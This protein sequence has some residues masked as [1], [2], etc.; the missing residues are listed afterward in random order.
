[1]FQGD[2]SMNRVRF[3][4][5][6]LVLLFSNLPST[7]QPVQAQVDAPLAVDEA[8]TALVSSGVTSYTLADPKIFWH[9]GVPICPPAGP[10][11]AESP[12][13][14]YPE[15]IKRVARYGSQ[16]RTLYEQQQNCSTGQ[17]LSN[18]AA[19]TDFIYFYNPTGLMKLSTLANPGDVPQI[20]NALV[21]APGE[22]VDGGDRVFYIAQNTTGNTQV[23]YVLKS[24]NARVNFALPAAIASNLSFDGKFAYYLTNG[25]LYRY[26]PATA[27]LT[28]LT[29]GVTGYYAEGRRLFY[30]TITP[31][32]CVYTD[33]VYIA[34][35]RFVYT[36]NNDTSTL[37]TT[38]I[39][40]STDASARIEEMVT[41]FLNLFFFERRTVPCSP[42]P[43]FSQY[44]YLLQRTTRGGASLSSL[45]VSAPTFSAGPSNLNTT[46]GFLFWDEAGKLNRLP[47]DVAALPVINMSFTGMEIT[48]GIQSLNN[49]VLLIKNRRTFVRVYVKSDGNAVPGVTAQLF[50]PSLGLGPLNPVN[51]NGTKITVRN[52][53]NRS[54]IEESFLFEL[55]WSWIQGNSL[56]LRADLNPYKVPLEP[57]YAD[58]SISRTVSLVNSPNLSVEFFSLN[59][60]I[61]NETFIPRF[62]E[63]FLYTYSWI[64]R[65]YPIGGAIGDKFKPR[66]WDVD[67]GEYLGAL[68]M[69]IHDVCS[70]IYDDPD[71]D[72]S[73]CASY[74]TNTWLWNYR[75]NTMLGKLNIG[76]SPTAFYYGMISD[77]AGYFP[78]GQ[79]R[80]QFTSVGPAGES[81]GWD[82]DGTYADWYAAHEIGHSLG[83]AHPASG[84]D[85]PNTEDIFELCRHSR[86]DMNYPYG[87]ITTASAPIGPADKSIFGFDV[88]DAA[89]GLAP[90]VLPSDIWNDVMSY[91]NNQWLSDYTYTAFYNFMMANPS[92]P[93]VLRVNT[94]AQAGDWL[95]VSGV[96]DPVDNEGAF[97][98][99]QRLENVINTPIITPGPYRL[100]LLDVSNSQ[101][102]SQDFSTDLLG[103]DP[104]ESFALVVPF[105][106]GARTIELS[107]VRTGDVL[108]T[109]AI[110]ANPP[111]ISNVAL[112]GA[113]NPVS[114]EVT[115]NWVA[116]DPDMD[117]LT[118]EILYSTDGGGTFQPVKIGVT[119]Q[120]TQI[121]TASLGGSVN[122]VFRVIASD[123]VHT[124]YAD[125]APFNMA[126]KPPQPIIM[127]PAEGHSINYGQLVNFSG[128]ALDAIDGT[129][130]ASGLQWRNAQDV[131]LG[132]GPLFS[133]D[134]LPVG[135]N[136]ITLQ[137]TNSQGLTASTTVTVYVGDD[138]NLPGPT[139][140]A[141]PDK[142]GWHV[143]SGATALQQ[144]T[145]S[146]NNSGSGSLNWNASDN[147]PWLSLSASSGSVT[148]GDASALVL[149]ANPSGLADNT[150]HQAILTITK[151]ASGSVPEQTVE[152]L[153]VLSIG[154][155]WSG[156]PAITPL[157]VR[158]FM[159]IM[160]R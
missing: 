126:N 44:N 128:M 49:S 108:A 117:L 14:T 23:G 15:T 77:A 73:L 31:P 76:L 123:G 6:I 62:E 129:V 68:V 97:G 158:V 119:E 149:T 34:K 160:I 39:Y 80:Y 21:D 101:L 64:Q 52:F 55:P 147:A 106:S 110:S 69:R 19:D 134:T 84:S 131:V 70:L 65:A 150:T 10:E 137:A 107:A 130:A 139:L 145:V 88:G 135:A 60:T 156:P 144:Y 63:D 93:E 22:V 41:D 141:S 115:L 32:N 50:A 96:I 152:I 105:V 94:Q 114:G 36:Y 3:L 99:V 59:Y 79:A 51:P 13:V 125:S 37:N 143:S 109:Y 157:S 2:I 12:L 58:N 27:Q 71:D 1:M 136:V 124:A 56:T 112:Q 104:V 75:I 138:L 148:T 102:S 67:G 66:I 118:F 111:V 17:I 57:N 82:T 28:L 127:N 92:R 74:V 9:T 159:P 95:A 35:G 133:S 47:N 7:A 91:C 40:T 83:R 151:P 46:D 122:G 5:L 132:T 116:S 78:R 53:P 121:D 30:C 100:R 11:A 16:N 81:G 142:V 98:L 48:Q 24:N 90:A 89:L 153:V 85:N 86:S 87:N 155:T 4:V 72:I 45:Y 113:P 33:N 38:A 61:Q 42:E 29:N 18:L 146:I 43:C 120:T 140:T 20:M 8:P 26:N 54:A 103:E 25:N 154:D